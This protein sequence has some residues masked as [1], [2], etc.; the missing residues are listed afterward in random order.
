LAAKK[1]GE[2]SLIATDVI[3]ALPEAVQSLGAD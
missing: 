1:L 2:T 3:R